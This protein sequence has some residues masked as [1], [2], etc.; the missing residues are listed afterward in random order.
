LQEIKKIR[1]YDQLIAHGDVEVRKK[2]LE[3]MDAVLQDVDAGKRIREIMSLN[4]DILTVGECTWDLSKKKNI[5]LIGAGKACNAMAEAVCDI[6]GERICKGIISVKI[7]EEQDHYCN[8]DVYTGGHPLPNEEGMEA[9]KRI[10][11][12]IDQA[13]SDDLFISVIS[14]G[15]S[16]LLTYPVEGITLED[17][18]MTQDLLLKS[19]AKIIEINAVRRHISRTNGGR[20]A[21]MICKKNGSELISLM[22]GDAVGRPPTSNRGKSVVFYGTPV[23]ADGT[24]IQDARNMIDNYNLAEKLPKS[25]VDF[26]MDDAK[27]KETPKEFDNKLTT[28]L[29]GSLSDSCESAIVAA[30]NMGIPLIILTTFL[31]G[32]SREA[33]QFLSSIAREIKAME[34]P[35]TPPCFIICAGETTTSIDSLPKGI[36]GPSQEL[37]LGLAIGIKNFKGI[38]GASIDTEGTDGSTLYAGGIVD[39]STIDRLEGANVNVYEA[40]RTHFSGNALMA[41]ED[42]IFTGNTGTN[43]CDFNVIYI[44]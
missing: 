1:N 34:R 21:E 3:L 2:V 14:G 32:E 31:E 20:I 8:T 42:N 38:A 22:V 29:V 23:A 40:L 12:L 44:S 5:Y 43:L 17:E 19:G 11:E 6:M 28:F 36:G 41:I 18:I 16:A 25:V 30:D 33:G 39:G 4:G 15:S 24:T 10:I 13:D 9:A 35:I 26:I 7:E 27:I 37:V